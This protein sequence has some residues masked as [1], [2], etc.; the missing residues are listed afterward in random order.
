MNPVMGLVEH[1]ASSEPSTLRGPCAES[2]SAARPLPVNMA[3][4]TT[5]S[6]AAAK[7]APSA[8]VGIRKRARLGTGV[9]CAAE[10]AG[11]A[12]GRG[13]G[14]PR[15]TTLWAAT[16]LA[17]R[18]ERQEAIRPPIVPLRSALRRPDRGAETGG[19]R[20]RVAGEPM[21]L[22]RGE[23]SERDG[24]AAIRAIR[25]AEALRQ[26]CNCGDMVAPW[27]G[28]LATRRAACKQA[29]GTK[30]QPTGNSLVQ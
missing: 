20:E 4:A 28:R 3:V 7:A 25:M 18:L 15:G 24:D 8:S 30:E 13:A 26:W 29:P 5:D 2:R 9:D 27:R 22:A 6:V 12:L 11:A 19:A 14:P 21:Q 17:A 23:G 16:V 1:T 10:G